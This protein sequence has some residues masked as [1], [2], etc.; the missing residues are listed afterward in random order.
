MLACCLLL[1]ALFAPTAQAVPVLE[2]EVDPG[3]VGSEAENL[4]WGIDSGESYAVV[5]LRFT[6][7]KQL[8]FPDGDPRKL[9]FTLNE[10]AQ[11][12]RS[13][14]IVGFLLDMDDRPIDGT[15][16]VGVA[17]LDAFEVPTPGDD[18]FPEG[19]V[20]SGILLAGPFGSDEGE[21]WQLTW[22]TEPTVVPEP[23]TASLLGLGLLALA[24]R[25]RVRVH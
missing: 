3:V 11:G 22:I 23:G 7:G 10:L 9:S 2:V 14:I 1:T 8:A 4:Q 5:T 16:F 18:P 17:D 12:Q 6:D 20:W 13:P 15:Q 19:T 21:A 24:A 25:R